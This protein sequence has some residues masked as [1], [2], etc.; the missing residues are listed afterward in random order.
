MVMTQNITLIFM[1]ISMIVVTA[2]YIRFGYSIKEIYLVAASVFIT[3]VS[4]KN[5]LKPHDFSLIYNL[6]FTIAL[7]AMS[8]LIMP[9]TKNVYYITLINMIAYML[10]ILSFISVDDPKILL[11]IYTSGT[12]VFLTLWYTFVIKTFTLSSTLIFLYNCLMIYIFIRC[13]H[14][15]KTDIKAII[16][17]SQI[18]S[19]LTNTSYI[20]RSY[21]NVRKQKYFSEKD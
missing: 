2:Y 15:D 13:E 19:F 14:F 4:F 9:S 10:S 21:L 18:I 7:Y 11:V 3:I 16:I 20:V 12:I 17:F 6:Y 5:M 8:S 1:L